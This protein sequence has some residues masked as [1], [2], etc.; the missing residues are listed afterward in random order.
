LP[1]LDRGVGYALAHIPGGFE[2]GGRWWDEG[3]L[4]HKQNVFADFIARAEQ[5]VAAGYTTPDR[6]GV[7]GSS[8]GGSCQACS[9]TS[10]AT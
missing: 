8:N 7:S 2:Y 3:K 6:L 4:L 10:V 1:L 9:P 5:L